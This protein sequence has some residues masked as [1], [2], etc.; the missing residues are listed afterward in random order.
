MA[1]LP[2]TYALNA[3][4]LLAWVRRAGSDLPSQ[5]TQTTTSDGS[6][7]VVID[8]DGSIT[9]QNVIVQGVTL[10][11]NAYALNGVILTLT[12]APSVGDSVLVVYTR[13]KFSND[14]LIN[15]LVDS[16]RFVGADI[17]THWTIS[18]TDFTIIDT[19]T[20]P[21]FWNEDLSLWDSNIEA[22]IV[23]KSAMLLSQ[24]R[25]NSAAADAIKIKDGDTSI[26]TSA[27]AKAGETAFKRNKELYD[28][29][30]KVVRSNRFLGQAQNA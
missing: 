27:T 24:E 1:T 18:P 12:A 28:E 16:S 22:L 26:D 6:T 2:Y 8:N 15:Y 23:Y 19:Q 17:N 3:D 14:D 21:E 5:Y 29:N 9:I 20:P 7:I 13:T 25:V 4:S 10:A 11:T 30:L